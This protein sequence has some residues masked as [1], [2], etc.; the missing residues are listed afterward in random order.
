[1]EQR[2]FFKGLTIKGDLTL[3]GLN[4]RANITMDGGDDKYDV[5]HR[6][7]Q[8]RI[9]A[10]DLLKDEKISVG[11]VLMA[12]VNQYGNQKL[13]FPP[14]MYGKG[15]VQLRDILQYSPLVAEL[16]VPFSSFLKG[17]TRDLGPFVPWPLKDYVEGVSI[18][19]SSLSLSLSLPPSLSPSLSLVFCLLYAYRMNTYMSPCSP[20]F[21]ATS[22]PT[23]TYSSNLGPTRPRKGT[24]TRRALREPRRSVR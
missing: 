5:G 1:M 20:P 8:I 2:Q 18:S 21:N 11:T 19:P 16:R 12:V 22:T 9:P 13:Y 17:K 7:A 3:F 4:L 15:V 14:E 23:L 24:A 10:E 6:M